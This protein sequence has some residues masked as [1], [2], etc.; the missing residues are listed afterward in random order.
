MH[1]ILI[2]FALGTSRRQS[3][4]ITS[5]RIRCLFSFKTSREPDWCM[6]QQ[7]KSSDCWTRRTG[8]EG[9][10]NS[11]KVSWEYN[12]TKA[13]RLVRNLFLLDEL[14]MLTVFKFIAWT[15]KLYDIKFGQWV[16]PNNPP[17]TGNESNR[18]Y[19]PKYVYSIKYIPTYC[20]L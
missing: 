7:P 5:W 6:C 15:I 13:T 11:R 19:R 2:T 4:K 3:R 20:S 12:Y 8:K 10:W 17:H 1:L 16:P 18:L 14:K 9:E